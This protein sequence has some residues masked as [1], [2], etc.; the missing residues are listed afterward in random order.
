MEIIFTE[1]A[2]KDIE[3]WQKSG[4]VAMLKR[5]RTLV[6]S[7]LQSPFA[8]I[9]KPEPLKYNLAGKWSRRITESDRLVYEVKEELIIIYSLRGHYL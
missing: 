2:R 8:G 7:L 1:E 3:W 9:G 6:E 4:K 5:I